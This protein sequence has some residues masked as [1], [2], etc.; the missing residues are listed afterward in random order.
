MTRRCR[1]R[2][3]D[4]TPQIALGRLGEERELAPVTLPK[5]AFMAEHDDTDIQ[6]AAE[7][8]STMRV[9]R[10]GRDAL[11]TLNKA[12]SYDSWLKVGAA[13]SIGKQWVLTTS[14]ANCAWGSVYS[15][16]FNRWLAEHEK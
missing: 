15:K 14:G 5:L 1:P 8:L 2:T 9:I 6:E 12:Q 10:V 16:T 13:L 3:W 7:R 4:C 11:E